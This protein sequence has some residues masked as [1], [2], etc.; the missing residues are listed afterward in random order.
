S[1][2]F[3]KVQQQCGQIPDL[4]TNRNLK[5]L[6]EQHIE[7][8]F[9]QTYATDLFVFAKPGG[10]TGPIPINDL[11]Y[12]AWQY[13]IPQIQIVVPLIVICLGLDPFNV[14]R[15]ALCGQVGLSLEQAQQEMTRCG[16]SEI[17]VVPHTGQWMSAAG[18]LEGVAP[19]WKRIAN[20]LREL[21]DRRDRRNRL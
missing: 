18:G 14:L 6:L 16:Q 9:E 11:L 2:P 1:G 17:F 3:N 4:L 15:R 10:M 12:C 21:R 13:A 7:L 8:K 20:R 5:T 19:Q